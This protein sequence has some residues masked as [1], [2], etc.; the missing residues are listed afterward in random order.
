MQSKKRSF[1]QLL[2]KT[3]WTSEEDNAIRDNH[4]DLGMRWSQ[5]TVFLPG[6][7]ENAI[8][9]RCR[10]LYRKKLY[11]TD[12]SDSSD[13]SDS[14]II[15]A[16]RPFR[17]KGKRRHPDLPSKNLANST[18]GGEVTQE[19]KITRLQELLAAR[20]KLDFKI[21]ELEENLSSSSSSDY[22]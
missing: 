20:R 22:F 16:K 9:S 6:R 13:S 1:K 11:S 19:Q 2:Q 7:S 8:H 17:S 3:K 14:R 18:I 4:A 21:L 12:G 10:E 15:P 5:Y